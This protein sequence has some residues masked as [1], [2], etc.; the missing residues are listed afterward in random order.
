[1]ITEKNSKKHF[2]LTTKTMY[3]RCK[4]GESHPEQAL[5]WDFPGGFLDGDE[6][7]LESLMREIT[8]ETGLNLSSPKLKNCLRDDRKY[9]RAEAGVRIIYA[10]KNTRRK[11]RISS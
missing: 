5:H 6:E 9:C 1:M 10:G 4:R 8:E 3:S 7:P 2:F 11:N